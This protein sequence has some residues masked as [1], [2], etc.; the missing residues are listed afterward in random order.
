MDFQEFPKA[1][2]REAECLIVADAHEEE[3]ARAGGFRFWSDPVV[4]TKTYADGGT[5]TGVAPL[6]DQSPAEQA[7]EV[8]RGPGRPKKTQ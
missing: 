5:A 4:E 3:A 2:Y 7:A 6:P 1:L 8:K